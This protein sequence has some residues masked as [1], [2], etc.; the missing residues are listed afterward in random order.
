MKSPI[1]ALVVIALSISFTFAQV[2]PAAGDAKAATKAADPS[3]VELAKA[4]LAAHGG[5]R[6]KKMSA[7]LLKGGV[8]LNVSNQITSGA[9]SAAQSGNKYFFEI[10][11]P[12]QSFKQICDGQQTYSSLSGI[13]LPPLTS[14]G[15]TVIGHVGEE[16]YTVA[17][18][19]DAKKKG[20]G[21]RITAPDGF[22]TDFLVDEKTGQVKSFDSAFELAD[23]RVVTTSAIIDE[24]QTVDG[25][26]VPKKYSQRFDFGGFTAYATFKVKDVLVNPQMAEN[27]FAF[28]K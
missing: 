28:P 23:G 27:A 14:T 8:D 1:L 6:F 19:G 22:F 15:F 16:G 26:T 3:P 13:M 5:D 9:F 4:A 18:F 24:M 11:T 10:A 7:L 2:P 17:A 12:I 25:L 21:F 20:R